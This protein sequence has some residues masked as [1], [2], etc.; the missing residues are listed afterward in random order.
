MLKV[1]VPLTTANL[2][3]GFDCFGLALSA[4]N[5]YHFSS[6][7]KMMLKGFPNELNNENNLLY[8]VYLDMFIKNKRPLHPVE[9]SFIQGLPLCGGVG[10]SATAIIAAII[11]YKFFNQEK[12]TNT[13]LINEA[14]EYEKHPDNIVAAI[15]GGFTTAVLQEDKA[16]KVLTAKLYTNPNWKVYLYIPK[17][18]LPTQ[19]ARNILPQEIKLSDAVFNI[20]RV[21][22]IPEA[23]A[24][25]D[26]ELLFSLIE[27][28]LHEDYRLKL[29][30][31]AQAIKNY[32]KKN[33]F[34]C[35][36]SGAGASMAIITKRNLYQD[37][38]NWERREYTINNSGTT[39]EE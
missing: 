34:P 11:A 28:R 15:L 10:S 24:R 3:P 29:I 2:G 33:N 37:F 31:G 27:D 12:I 22:M 13:I 5:T 7:R 38:E 25:G 17:I 30:P 39:Y 1:K 36:L 9:I 18:N 21:S 32:A 6:S 4:Y 35:F 20:S 16:K 14:L 26:E 8:K 19:T 23:L